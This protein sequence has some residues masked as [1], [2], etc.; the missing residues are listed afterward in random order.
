MNGLWSKGAIVLAVA[1]CLQPWRDT[2]LYAQAQDVGQLAGAI[3]ALRETVRQGFSDVNTRLDR[4]LAPKWEYRQ[5]TPNVLTTKSGQPQTAPDF[6]GLGRE[7]WEL[8]LYDQNIGYV[9]K[10][11][12]R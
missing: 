11:M 8:V 4:L 5:F 1:V 10:R 6:A 12:A 2:P 7:G 9:F 3:S